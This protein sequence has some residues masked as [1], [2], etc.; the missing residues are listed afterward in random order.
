[1]KIIINNNEKIVAFEEWYEIG[2]VKHDG[3]KVVFIKGY[4]KFKN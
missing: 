2:E 3:Q 4:W 1:M